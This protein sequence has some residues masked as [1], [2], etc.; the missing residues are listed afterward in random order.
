[1]ARISA[2]LNEALFGLLAS[3]PDV[4][5]LGEDIADPYGGAF[6]ITKGLSEKFPGRVLSTPISEAGV[7]G[8]ACGLALC[9]KTVIVEVMFA[10]FLT[11]AGDQIVNFASKSVAMYGREL[12]MRIIVRCPSGGRR[13][14]GATHSQSLQKHFIG[15][16]NLKIYE[17]S[18]VHDI[19]KVFANMAA[20]G[21][22]CVFVEDKSLYGEPVLVGDRVDDL[23]RFTSLGG[24]QD[25]ARVYA[26]GL[27]DLDH[28]II[29]PG[30]MLGRALAAARR[31][32]GEHE[33]VCQVVVP[34]RLFPVDVSPLAEMLER[35]RGVLVVEESTAGGTWGTEV[36]TAIYEALWGRLRNRVRLVSSADS[37]IPA[38][39]HLE[40]QIIVGEREIFQELRSIRA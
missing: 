7:M 35:A 38:A 1:M 30:G 17:L 13:G 39:A 10:D 25:Y 37:V 40:R 9:G 8:A 14:Y 20:C 16:P 11:L 33:E 31:L 3:D 28:V 24:E 36:A 27:D 4:Y 23:Y 34:S 29:A 26:D 19:N 18:A 12:P 21:S 5:V 32:L 2:S 22:P 15:V 6:K